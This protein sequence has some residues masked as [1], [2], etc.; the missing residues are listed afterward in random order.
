MGSVRKV[1]PN[2]AEMENRKNRLRGEW[3]GGQR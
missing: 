2:S 1:L 3:I